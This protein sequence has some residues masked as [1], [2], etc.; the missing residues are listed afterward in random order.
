MLK[1]WA[2]IRKELQLLFRDPHGLALLFI[3]PTAFIL[4][5]SLALQDTFQRRSGGPLSAVIVDFDQTD[6]SDEVIAGLMGRDG[7]N[8]TEIEPVEDL[9]PESLLDPQSARFV[10]ILPK[11]L[12]REF[13]RETDDASS[14][15]ILAAADVDRQTEAVFVSLVREVLSRLKVEQLL[16]FL[17]EEEG[18]D[19]EDGF[20]S[21]MFDTP[22][23]VIFPEGSDD[24]ARPS[25]V[26]QNVPAWL[27]FSIF[28]VSIP[29][30]N[31]FIT[32]RELGVQRR[33]RGTDMHVGIQLFGKF[34]PY[35]VINLIQVGLMLAVGVWLLPLLG[36][37]KLEIPANPALLFVVGLAV[38][39]AALSFA[40][41]ISIVSRTTEQATMLS[42]LGNIILAA[43]GGIM[44]PRF[45][46]PETMQALSD[47]S[48]MAWGLD[49]FLALLLHG[50]SYHN[51]VGPI[52]KLFGLSV[53]LIM[54]SGLIQRRTRKF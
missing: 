29:F 28:F 21:S 36:G 26:Q 12:K 6:R 4:I 34:I 24:G 41:F 10:V 47:F 27:V 16:D 3:L 42:G 23:E 32:E 18:L 31:T 15:E 14:I 54:V 43:I 22:I 8:F 19:D 2:S 1:L 44:V 30:S 33:L 48:P 20:D 37:E 51:I 53:V 45:V 52:A 7:F 25:S 9:D 46:M 13:F 38:S 39:C 5:M 49:A 40:L 11:G 17:A 50:H 35:L